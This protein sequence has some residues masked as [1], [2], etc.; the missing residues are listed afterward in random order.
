MKVPLLNFAGGP[1]V[2]LL[3]FEEGPGVPLLNFR[4]VPGRTFKLWGGSRVPCPR[5][6]RSRGPGPTFTPCL[7]WKVFCGLWAFSFFGHPLRGCYKNMYIIVV[8]FFNILLFCLK[9]YSETLTDCTS[10]ATSN[11][12]VVI[13]VFV[14]LDKSKTKYCFWSETEGKLLSRYLKQISVPCI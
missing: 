14:H 3:N 5:L 7:F 6:P 1:G 4:E 2:P 8:L 12:T 11:T 9:G 13:H 10:S